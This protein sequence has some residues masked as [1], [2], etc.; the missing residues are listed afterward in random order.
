MEMSL[1]NLG[2]DFGNLDHNCPSIQKFS[3]IKNSGFVLDALYGDPLGRRCLAG[4]FSV[5]TYSLLQFHTHMQLR[6][7]MEHSVMQAER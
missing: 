3:L 2:L 1:K 6:R 5:S 4:V 7:I